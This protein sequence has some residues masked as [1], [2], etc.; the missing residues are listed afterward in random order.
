L[1]P[2]NATFVRRPPKLDPQAADVTAVL[3][4]T[5]QASSNEK[6]AGDSRNANDTYSEVA[7]AVKFV[8]KKV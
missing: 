8:V 2:W 5:T 4:A 6:Y 1:E 7:L 3:P